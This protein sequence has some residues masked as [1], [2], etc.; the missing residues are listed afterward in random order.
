MQLLPNATTDTAVFADVESVTVSNIKQAEDLV[1]SH[2]V[3]LV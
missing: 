3:T 1:M 2:L